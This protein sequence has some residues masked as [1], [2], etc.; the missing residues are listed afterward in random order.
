MCRLMLSLIIYCQGCVQR[1]SSKLLAFQ[2]AFCQG[3]LKFTFPL[4]RP[5]EKRL[6][7]FFCTQFFIAIGD[8]GAQV[9]STAGFVNFA[10][11]AS[12]T[13]SV[14]CAVLIGALAGTIKVYPL[15]APHSTL[16]VDRTSLL[17]RFVRRYTRHAG[18]QV[19]SRQL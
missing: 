3:K 14:E 6:L 5:F 13:N 8:A 4:A 2:D 19:R 1:N 18:A 10:T 9:L 17:T 12:A 11:K 15:L 16:M 7:S